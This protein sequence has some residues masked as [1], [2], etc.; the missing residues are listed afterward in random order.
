MI[1]NHI[2]PSG[3][4]SLMGRLVYDK[5][6]TDENIKSNRDEKRLG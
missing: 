5:R 3:A 6:K 2:A 4:E 1:Q